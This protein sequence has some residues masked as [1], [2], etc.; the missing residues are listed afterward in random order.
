MESISTTPLNQ[1]PDNSKGDTDLV[2]KI[3]TQLETSKSIENS[4]NN[5]NESVS[6]IDTLNTENVEIAQQIASQP[7][8]ENNITEEI[9]ET[10]FVP[11][12]MPTTSTM[13]TLY[14][15]I[16]MD[17][18]K[19]ILK[20]TGIYTVIFFVFVYSSKYFIKLFTKLPYLVASTGDEL[21]TTGYI[22]QSLLF[23][24]L[25]FFITISGFV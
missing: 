23:G 1:L 10:L 12:K 2:N 11:D 8:V 5:I 20:L 4:T 7:I 22:L 9:K 25:Y 16:N 6:D 17:K 15:S 21:N 13:Q 18:L 24:V 19:N 14:E 3:L